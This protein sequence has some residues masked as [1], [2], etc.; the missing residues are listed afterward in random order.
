MKLFQKRP[1]RTIVCVCASVS[2]YANQSNLE[3]YVDNWN[4]PGKEC[5]LFHLKLLAYMHFRDFSFELTSFGSDIDH[6]NRLAIKSLAV[7]MI[8]K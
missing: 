3:I 6:I 4:F 2:I 1:H 7:I 5:T 8:C